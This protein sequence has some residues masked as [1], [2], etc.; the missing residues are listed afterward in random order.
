MAELT[1]AIC[2]APNTG[3]T[4]LFNRLTGANQTVGNWPGVTVAKKSGHFQLDTHQILLDDLPGAYSLTAT[5][6]EERISRDYLLNSPPD[7]IINVVDGGNLY[8]GLGLTLQL[9]MSGLPMVVVVN[10]MDEVRAKGIDIDFDAFSEHLGLPVLPM[11]A[12]TGEGLIKLKHTLLSVLQQETVE[13][14]PHISFPPV[15]EEAISDLARKVEH[16][17]PTG[18]DQ[19]F[20]AIRLMEGGESATRVVDRYPIL[21]P[22]VGDAVAIRQHVEQHLPMDLPTTC[23][24]CRFNSVRGLVQEAVKMPPQLPKDMTAQLDRLLMHRYL[25]LPL[26]LLIMFI[27]FQGVF[28]LGT[29]LQETLAGIFESI[30]NVLRDTSLIQALPKLAQSFLLDGLLAGLGVVLSF[31]PIIMLFFLFL[32]IIED[33]GYMA[34]AAFLMDRL[35]HLLRLDGKA[36]ISL[37]LGYGCNVPA[38]MGTR[39]L[40]SRHNRLLAMLLVPFT[41][42]SA[43][44]QVFLFLSAILF[45]ATVAPWVVFSLYLLSFFI[46]I[47]IGLLLRPFRFGTAEPFI[48]ELPPYRL[49]LLRTVVLRAWQEIRG[50]LYR[51]ATLI[52]LGVVVIWFLTHIPTTAQPGSIDTLAGGIGLFLAPLF[53]PLGIHWAETVALFFGF[54]AKEILIGALAVIYGSANLAATIHTQLSPLQGLSFMVFTLI[55]TPCVATVAAIRSE[56][57]SWRIT[58]LS[59]GIGL[60]LAWLASFIMYQVGLLLGYY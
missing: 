18:S 28:R 59:M 19:T 27:L 49:P 9:A 32:S 22:L 47:L 7:A 53:E 38:I 35:M 60:V 42:C 57:R 52:V 12:R 58:L 34:R 15:L 11:V 50:F 20:I 43:R 37:L 29:P 25:G 54:I 14:P 3:K 41:L 1:V 40:S 6:L 8:R 56:S 46:I 24:Q 51:A 16:Q 44:L 10:M 55:Y 36:F 33:S 17:L 21:T 2:A 13:H 4:T 30:N 31:V 5:S 48:M 45:S 23:A 26:F 39:I